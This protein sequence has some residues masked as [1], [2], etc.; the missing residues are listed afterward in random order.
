MPERPIPGRST[1]SRRAVTDIIRAAVLGSYGVA[2][3]A[4]HE[5]SGRLVRWLGLDEPGIRIATE[6]GLR[7]D[8][9]LNVAHGL[10]VAEVAR[11][12]DSA[13][14]YALRRALEREVAELTIHIDGLRFQPGR[15]PDLAAPTAPPA[16]APVGR[17]SSSRGRP[18]GPVWTDPSGDSEAARRTTR[19]RRGAVV[20]DDR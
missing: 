1:V 14:R 6:D 10:P 9:H 8:L 16:Q 3:F 7:I 11:Q 17:A 4:D 12:V 13:V 19:R 18:S 20:G 2:G 5:L 15:P